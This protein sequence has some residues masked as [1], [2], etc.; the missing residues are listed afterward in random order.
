MIETR[1]SIQ[2]VEDTNDTFFF[3]T[4]KLEMAKELPFHDIKP[5][6]ISH[7]NTDTSIKETKSEL[8][9]QRYKPTSKSVNVH[10]GNAYVYRSIVD[11]ME[12]PK[13]WYNVSHDKILH[14]V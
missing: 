10:W 7:A 12:I 9:Y 4:S 1:K 13:M 6:S 3:H 11:P 2:L 14:Y 5:K 8:K